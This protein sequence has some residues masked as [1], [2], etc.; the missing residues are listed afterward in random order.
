[1]VFGFD[2]GINT[3][4]SI[5]TRTLSHKYQWIVLLRWLT[6]VSS[7]TLFVTSLFFPA[8]LFQEVDPVTGGN[9]LAW[10]WWGLILG[11]PAWCANPVFLMTVFVFLVKKYVFALIG[12][13]V[14]FVLGAFSF[15]ANEYYFS[16]ASSRPIV[17]LGLHFIFGC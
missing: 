2:S 15:F 5:A 14:A 13:G 4:W 6:I 9:L 11:N 8:L 16:E 12:G 1:M 7:S 3:Y 10:G 17:G